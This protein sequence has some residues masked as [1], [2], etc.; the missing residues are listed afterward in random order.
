VPC[1][2]WASSL[3]IK[4]KKRKTSEERKK[5]GGGERLSER[6]KVKGRKKTE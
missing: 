4:R 5:A 1:N 6:G 3:Q 2:E